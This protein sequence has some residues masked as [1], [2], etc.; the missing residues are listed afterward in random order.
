MK[1]TVALIA[2]NTT[3]KFLIDIRHRLWL[4][5]FPDISDVCCQVIQQT[6]AAVNWAGPNCE[7]GVVLA[8]DEFITELNRKWRSV[9]S[10]TNVLAFPCENDGSASYGPGDLLLGDIVVSY[11]TLQGEANGKQIPLVHHL[12]HLIIHGTLHLLGFNH[13]EDTDA[14]RMERLEI[15]TLSQL[16]IDNPYV[17]DNDYF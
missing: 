2:S 14:H 13:I 5:D 12:S 6:F 7:V 10:P 8:D 9:D 16:G 15:Q 1:P 11:E 17:E 4:E 3:G